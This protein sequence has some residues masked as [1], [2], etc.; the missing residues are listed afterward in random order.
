MAPSLSASTEPIA[1]ESDCRC[2][3]KYFDMVD[4]NQ[5]CKGIIWIFSIVRRTAWNVLR[6]WRRQ[7]DTKYLPTLLCTDSM[8]LHVPGDGAISL[9][10]NKRQTENSLAPTCCAGKFDRAFQAFPRLRPTI[11]SNT[12]SCR[13]CS[14]QHLLLGPQHWPFAFDAVCWC[15][16]RLGTPPNDPPRPAQPST[17]RRP[18]G[19]QRGQSRRF[20]VA[21]ATTS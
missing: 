13:R 11:E 4:I 6:D 14:Q 16:R 12:A 20:V 8:G 1:L 15:S 7:K 3:S 17:T 21:L 18:A 19:F 2:T 9:A 5:S 10:K